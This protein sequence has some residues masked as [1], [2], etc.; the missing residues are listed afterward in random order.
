[1]TY[2]WCGRAAAAGETVWLALSDSGGPYAEA[3]EAARREIQRGGAS[4]EIGT[5]QQFLAPGRAPPPL[6]IAI[7]SGAY[8]GL[9][10]SDLRAPLLATLLPRA[11]FE[12][13]A[14][15]AARQGRTA[16]AVYLDQPP[17]R[18]LDLLRLTLP[19]RRRIGVLYGPESRQWAPALRQASAE[20]GVTLAVAEM[21]AG[22]G[23]FPL[24][25]DLIDGS[26]MLLA[27]PDPHVFNSL[28]VQNILTAT[29]RR[30]IPLIGFSPAYVKA[31]ALLAVYSTPSQV[32]A[33]AGEIARAWLAG[34]PLPAPQ[35]PR[36]FSIGVNGDVARSLGIAFAPDAAE[37][38]IEQLRLKERAP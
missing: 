37:K 7:G 32:G 29:Y 34:R 16:T 2:T 20:R 27:M 22:A 24:L 31:G 21:A 23:L 17:A 38:W 25:Q 19:E 10:E 8:A 13:H 4:A 11:A 35:S 36:E 3:A 14:E 6:V 5:W 18:L 1:M 30:R 12:R 28:T 15:R 33:Q 26:D 9:A